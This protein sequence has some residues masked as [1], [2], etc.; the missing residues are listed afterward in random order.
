MRREFARLLRGLEKAS[1]NLYE[2]Y[3]PE[4]EMYGDEGYDDEYGAYGDEEGL[5]G[6]EFSQGRQMGQQTKDG[7]VDRS[8]QDERIVKVREIALQGLQD[9]AE[10]ITNPLYL[11]WKKIWLETDKMCN[12]KSEQQ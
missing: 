4:D 11:F 10:D 12:D 5:D 6:E 2:A 7:G 3:M 1:K 8:K 9:Y